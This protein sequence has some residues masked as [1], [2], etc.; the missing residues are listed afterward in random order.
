MD[1]PTSTPHAPTS[2]AATSLVVAGRP[3]SE[4]RDLRDFPKHSH[5]RDNVVGYVVRETVRDGKPLYHGEKDERGIY[6]GGC[7]YDVFAVEGASRYDW[8]WPVRDAYRKMKGG[9]AVV[10]ELYSCGCR[11]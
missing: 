4:Y 10:D 9:Y 8:T 2:P 7:G 5:G 1:H 6:Q 3:I 11:S